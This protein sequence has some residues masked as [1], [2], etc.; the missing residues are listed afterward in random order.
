[1]SNAPLQRK[2]NVSEMKYNIKETKNRA[3]T[4]L[5]VCYATGRYFG[6]NDY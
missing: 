1:M 4:L 5:H 6:I 2:K 3:K